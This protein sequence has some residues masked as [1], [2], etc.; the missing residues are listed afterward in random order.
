MSGQYGDSTR[1]VKAAASQHVPGQPVSS[2][3]VPVS[4]YHLSADES[5]PGD[6]YGRSS[7]PTWRQLESAL[8]EL[9]GGAT[10]ALSFGSGD[11]GHHLGA[12]GPSQTGHHPGGPPAD[13]YY[14]VRLYAG[15]IPGPP[16][17]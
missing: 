17:A 10:S 14:Q 5:Q 3:P 13:G 6:T 9:E 11:G 15:G 4:A 12:A 7:N 16:S 1:S 8:A 2:P